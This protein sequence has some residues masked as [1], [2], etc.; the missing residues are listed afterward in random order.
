MPHRIS[1][2]VDDEPALR[3]YVAAILQREHFQTVEADN[4]ADGFEA[5]RKREGEVALIVTDV[6]M[7]G[8][9]GLTL[10]T[11]VRKTFPAVPII[12][13]SGHLRPDVDFEFVQKP[14]SPAALLQA[15]RNVL[16]A[17]RAAAYS[18]AS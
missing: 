3:A 17:H 13:V 14:F 1:L 8:G 5:V 6:Q 15:V 11:S 12:L 16:V 9:D 10:A 4:G 18:R 2:V 7:P